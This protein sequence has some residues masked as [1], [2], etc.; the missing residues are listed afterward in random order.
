MHRPSRWSAR[1][2]GIAR[3]LLGGLLLTV[4]SL[5]IA[6]GSGNRGPRVRSRVQ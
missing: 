6:D 3:A 2:V 1:P 5:A 4:A